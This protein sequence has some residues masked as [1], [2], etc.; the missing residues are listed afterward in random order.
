METRSPIDNNMLIGDT[1]ECIRQLL[2]KIR[3]ME[4][5][6]KELQTQVRTEIPNI[7]TQLK[8]LGGRYKM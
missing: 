5:Q 6:I 4:I 8:V 3:T 2:V 7:K 1:S